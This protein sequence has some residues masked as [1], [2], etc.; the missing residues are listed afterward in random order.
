MSR[1]KRLLSNYIFIRV[2]RAILTVFIVATLTFFIVRL[3]PGNP[4]E[5]YIGQLMSQYGMTFQDAKNQAA[6]L[7]SLDLD[8]PLFEQYIIYMKNL[9]RGDLGMSFL[10]QGTPVSLLIASYLPWTIFSVG[11][12]ILISF[13]LGILLGMISA[14]KRGGI[15]DHIIST[16]A[17]ILSAIPNYLIGI[18]LLIIIGVQLGLIPVSSMRGTVSPGITPGFNWTFIKDIFSHASLPILTYVV[19]TVGG[20]TL[21]M[22]SSTLNTISEDYVTVAKARGLPESR[23]TL[24]YVGRNAILPLFTSLTMQMGFLMGGST[25]IESIFVYKGIG[26]ALGSSIAQRDYPVMQAVFLIITIAVVVANFIADLLYS[27]LDPRIKVGGE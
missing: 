21:S 1:V 27:R 3:M 17:A 24:S 15:F 11:I 5:I 10:S 23:I 20:W 25:L 26:W 7:F 18:L 8:A 19:S 4:I 14:Y 22:K 9:L 2:V 12:S 16:I 13:T 6:A